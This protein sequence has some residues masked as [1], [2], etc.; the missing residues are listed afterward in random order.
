LSGS[1]FS[2]LTSGGGHDSPVFYGF[3][4]AATFQFVNCRD[5]RILWIDFHIKKDF[6]PHPPAIGVSKGK[7]PP[8]EFYE[9]CNLFEYISHVRRADRL[10]RRAFF[11][12]VPVLLFE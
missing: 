9:F 12:L 6:R 10:K 11:I 8:K 3:S 1:R 2:Y 5:K 7:I 4:Y